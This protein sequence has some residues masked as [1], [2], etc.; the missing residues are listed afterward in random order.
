MNSSVKFFDPIVT[1]LL[2]L[3]E[4]AWIVLPLDDDWLPLE[5]VDDEVL[6]FELP[7]AASASVAAIA[8]SALTRFMRVPSSRW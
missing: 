7:Q 3:A 5:L 6:L 1:L 4:L 2:W 8:A